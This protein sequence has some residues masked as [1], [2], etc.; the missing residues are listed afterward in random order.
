M[1]LTILAI[2]FTVLLSTPASA[3]WGAVY[4]FNQ[5]G[6]DGGTPPAAGQATLHGGGLG[7]T[8]APMGGMWYHSSPE[9]AEF[10]GGICL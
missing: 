3:F 7:D 4:I 8:M 9:W 6:W 1:K 5:H 2:L 10:I